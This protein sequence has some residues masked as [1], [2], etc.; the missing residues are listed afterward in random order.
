MKIAYFT[1]DDEKLFEIKVDKLESIEDEYVVR[2]V[3][4]MEEEAIEF[5]GNL[6]E[7]IFILLP[8]NDGEDF[9]LKYFNH[10]DYFKEGDNNFKIGSL[11]SH[12]V[13]RKDEENNFNFIC[14]ITFGGELLL[15]Q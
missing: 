11:I 12:T 1:Y 6:G 14:H 9:Y 7:E 4:Q 15:L 3:P 8:Y 5:L 2:N 10:A 13:G